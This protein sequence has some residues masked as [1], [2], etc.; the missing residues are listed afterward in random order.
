ML[1]K[2]ASELKAGFRHL[3]HARVRCHKGTQHS[4]PHEV[5]EPTTAR[6]HPAPRLRLMPALTPCDLVPRGACHWA[7]NGQPRNIHTLPLVSAI[8]PQSGPA[9]GGT[10]V[11]LQGL[12]LKRAKSCRFVG[13]GT[14]PVR[15]LLDGH[16][17]TIADDR[18]ECTVP[19]SPGAPR[20]AQSQTLLTLAME[21]GTVCEPRTQMAY[22]LF[23]Y[24]MEGAQPVS[25]STRGGTR[26]ELR[27]VGLGSNGGRVA[28]MRCQFG[29]T[30]VTP[31]TFDARRGSVFCVAPP[32]RVPLPPGR[33]TLAVP[34]HSIAEHS[35]AA[36]A[37]LATGKSHY[38]LLCYAMLCCQG[39]ATALA[40]PS[41]R[42]H[43]RRAA[44]ARA[45]RL[46]V[47][48]GAHSIA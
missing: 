5:L 48:R 47:R 28:D 11:V 8:A 26:V 31:D 24:S 30:I 22:G 2:N 35:T 39:A 40:Q 15:H 6:T 18:A 17:R 13:L 23:W 20:A 19:R 46:H 34:L 7:L 27:G 41:R 36:D 45:T 43:R 9:G 21:D 32:L 38:A 1:T 44:R 10:R 14:S 16:N 33:A 4:A 12:N 37:P 25:G 29:D 42:L 3:E